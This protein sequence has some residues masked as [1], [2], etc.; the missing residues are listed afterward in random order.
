MKRIIPFAIFL[1]VLTPSIAHA[2]GFRMEE[3]LRD[4][5]GAILGGVLL[6]LAFY[7]V[8][9]C[10]LFLGCLVK[11]REYRSMPKF[12][13]TCMSIGMEHAMLFSGLAFG[14]FL[15]GIPILLFASGIFV[16]VANVVF[17]ALFSEQWMVGWIIAVLVVGGAGAVA[18]TLR[19]TLREASWPIIAANKNDS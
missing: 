16:M 17:S 11:F 19:D 9:L 1:T 7:L 4:S 3:I 15:I 2:Y 13:S 10:S 5:D 14:Y 12:F 18:I 6:F 8:G